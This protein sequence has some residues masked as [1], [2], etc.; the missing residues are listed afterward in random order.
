MAELVAN[1]AALVS[2]ELPEALNSGSTQWLH[3]VAAT[4]Q[5]LGAH[6]VVA[7][8]AALDCWST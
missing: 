7:T 3:F 5:W 8:A 6:F 2:M 1:E 4:A